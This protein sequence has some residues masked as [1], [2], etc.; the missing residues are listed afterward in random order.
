VFPRLI[1]KI[2]EYNGTDLHLQLCDLVRDFA[3]NLVAG[4]RPREAV[5]VMRVLKGSLFWRTWSQG[6]LCMAGAL[7]NIALETN[8]RQDYL[9]A[10]AAWEQVPGSQVDQVRALVDNLKAKL[11]TL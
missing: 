11:Q 2:E 4:D 3:I 7:N 5:R 6:D 1:A 9:A 8:T 10:L